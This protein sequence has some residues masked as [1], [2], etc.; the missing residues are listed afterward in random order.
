MKKEADAAHDPWAVMQVVHCTSL[1]STS[2]ATKCNWSPPFQSEQ[3]WFS[4]SWPT[5][6]HPEASTNES[7][8]KV[9]G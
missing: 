5:L 4:G 2:N 7:G 3:T 8:V 6:H 1:E 9:S